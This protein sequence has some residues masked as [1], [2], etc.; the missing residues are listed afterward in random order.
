M[1]KVP[2]TMYCILVCAISSLFR[3]LNIETN[4]C[5]S[6]RFIICMYCMQVKNLDVEI[7]MTLYTLTQSTSSGHNLILTLYNICNVFWRLSYLDECCEF[8][9]EK[10]EYFVRIPSSRHLLK[11]KL[12]HVHCTVQKELEFTAW[13]RRHQTIWYPRTVGGYLFYFSKWQ[14]RFWPKNKFNK[15]FL[16]VSLYF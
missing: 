13:Q 7:L 9:L 1:F 6:M 3:T 15:F 10:W 4:Y 12:M 2:C 16:Q 8:C 14:K 5:Y 11:I